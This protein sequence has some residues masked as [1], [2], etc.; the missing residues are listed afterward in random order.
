MHWDKCCP[1]VIYEA[2][3]VTVQEGDFVAGGGAPVTPHRGSLCGFPPKESSQFDVVHTLLQ[4]SQEDV[5]AAVISLP[6]TSAVGD[7]KSASCGPGLR[8]TS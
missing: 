2:L 8:E 7:S 5:E 4:P 6:A 1:W 3:G